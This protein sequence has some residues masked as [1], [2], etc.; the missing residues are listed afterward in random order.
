[1]SAPNDFQVDPEQIREHAKTVADIAGGL[2]AAAG[3]LPGELAENALGTFVQFITAGLS[4][5]MTQAGEAIGNAASAMDGM[6]SALVQTAEGYERSDDHN[7][8]LLLGK[9]AR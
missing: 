4:G 6:S 3:G 1:M 2:S 5:A 9:D 7:V 8:G